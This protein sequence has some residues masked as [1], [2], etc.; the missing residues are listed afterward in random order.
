MPLAVIYATRGHIMPLAVT[1]PGRL[2]GD[3]VAGAAVDGSFKG[4]ACAAYVRLR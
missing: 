2:N 4:P 1:Y 3:G